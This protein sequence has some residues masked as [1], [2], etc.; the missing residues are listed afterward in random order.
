MAIQSENKTFR[1]SEKN[2]DIV[3][4]RWFDG[5]VK[6]KALLLIA[7]GMAEHVGRYDDFARFMVKK[8]YAVYGNDHLGHGKT[9]RPEDR[10]W[11]GEKDGRLNVVED[12]RTLLR[13][14]R[15]DFPGLKVLL[16][17][18]SMGSF[19][20]RLFCMRYSAEIDGAIFM[21]TSGRNPL[22]G[23]GVFLANLIALFRGERYV[24]PLY[25]K[26]TTG[27]YSAK[28]KHPK[29]GSDWLSTDEAEVRK[30]INDERCGFFFTISGYRELCKML[31]EINRRGWA[32][33]IRKDL[34][35]LLI[36][37]TEDPVGAFGAGV[38][39]VYR[40]LKDAGIGNLTLTL[41]E[42]MRHEVLNE[43]DKQRVY[44]DLLVWCDGQ[45]TK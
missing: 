15:G 14:A 17:G 10:G 44:N 4:T 43:K 20:A 19:I 45:F 9:A 6:P 18:H 5:G 31:I 36:S 29:T 28:Y 30:F 3:Y 32:A 33:G 42:G 38:R 16:L 26:L 40:R 21:G 13:T 27:S 37:G 34:P 7:H 35:V 24:S 25:A 11:F 23:F 2:T 39:E 1:S 41:Y 12:M 22:S 8:G